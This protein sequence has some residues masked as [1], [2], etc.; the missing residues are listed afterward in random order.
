MRPI[1]ALALT[2]LPLGALAETFD[3][4]LGDRV[5]GSLESTPSRLET[6]LDNTP[7]GLADGRFAAT[8][9]REG[10]GVLYDSQSD[11]RDIAFRAVAGRVRE[12][13][14]TPEG[15]R[16]DLSRPEAVDRVVADPVTTMSRLAGAEGCPAPFRMYDGRRVVEAVVTAETA[17]LA[18]L[19]CEMDYRVVAG[20][21][22]LSPFRLGRIGL[23]LTYDL[24]GGQR[25][26]RLRASAGGFDLEL[27]GR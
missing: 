24:A 4:L 21:G 18:T 9:T 6:V 19:V 13:T 8:L 20:P 1:L 26:T 22:H 3:V 7:L 5:I 16:T 12:V 23:R 15:E 11:K 27:R 17:S 2:L 10:D 25:L 14:I